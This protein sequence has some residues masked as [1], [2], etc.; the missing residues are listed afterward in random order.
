ADARIKKLQGVADLVPGLQ[1]D[2][3]NSRDKY[4]REE[5]LANGLQKEIQAKLQELAVAAKNLKDMEAARLAAERE[6]TN[7]RDDSKTKMGGME[8]ALL[9]LEQEV[10]DR[11]RELNAA[12]NTIETLQGEKRAVQ[13]EADRVRAAA[14]NRFAGIAL[15]GKRVLFLV[16]MSGSMEMVDYK[17]AA[18]EK[19]KGVR[20]SV[21]K[22]MRSLPELEKFQV[23]VF[24]DKASFPLGQEG[25][26]L[27]YDPGKSPEQVLQALAAIRPDG[28]T[29][30]YTAME[31]AFR[32]RA[33]GLDTIY[34]LSD[35]LPNMGEGLTAEQARTLDEIKQGELLGKYIRKKLKTEWN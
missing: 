34:L 22:V 35:G 30:M 19:W 28:G 6:L 1:D 7:V 13:A 32:F 3:K 27:D 11:K 15:T 21:A 16:D 17:V 25:R 4:A 10:Q 8:K 20:D 33:L 29:N 12:R 5:A 31:M 23:L 14:E 24:S 26:W 9:A 2:L 18:P